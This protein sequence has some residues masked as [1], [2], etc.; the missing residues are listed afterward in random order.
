VS[1]LRLVF[2]AVAAAVLLPLL[3]LVDKALESAAAELALERR[4]VAERVIDEMERELTAFLRREEDRPFGH[5]LY[6]ARADEADAGA[7][8]VRSPLAD[9][10]ESF[11]EGPFQLA[12]DGSASTP[13]WPDDLPRA[14][15]AGWQANMESRAKADLVL[16]AI[17]GAFPPRQRLDLGQEKQLPAIPPGPPGKNFDQRAGTTVALSESKAPMPKAKGESSPLEVLSQ[18]NRGAGQRA[19]RASKLAKTQS[20]NLESEERPTLVDLRLEPMVGRPLGNDRMLLYRTVFAGPVAYRQGLLI[21]K[22]ALVGWLAEKALEGAGAAEVRV[23]PDDGAEGAPAR[24]A[25]YR[26]RFAEPFAPV[27]ALVEVEGAGGASLRAARQLSALLVAAVLLGLFAVYRMAATALAYAQRRSDFVAAVTHELKTPL[28]AIRMYGEML[29]DEMVP[30][31]GKKKRYYE[32]IVAE[33][34]RLSRLVDNVLELARLERK[35]KKPAV[36][37]GEV[38]PILEEALTLLQPHAEKEGFAL[39]LEIEPNLPTVKV[40]RDALLQVIFNLVDNAIKYGRNAERKEVKI[41]ARRE[42]GEVVVEV[43]DQGPGVA[44]RQ[45]RRIF[46]PFWRGENELTRNTK[47][48]GIGLA[49]VRGLVERMGGQVGARSGATGGLE[50]YIQLERPT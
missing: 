2:L 17:R 16:E 41:A 1:K 44:P 3:L 30:D 21:D 40:D 35:E 37:A 26:H 10:L 13:L 29:R 9:P 22:K 46:E 27:V 15:L 12:P 43:A 34:E 49:L 5:Y 33:G 24:F 45:L 36:A 18:L 48:T 4:T 47:G 6:L 25:V 14:R 42:A 20:S 32:T 19:D 8:W 39:K 38:G 11:V 31:A 23:L 28:T 7:A 50:V